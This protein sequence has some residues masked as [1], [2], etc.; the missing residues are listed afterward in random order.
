MSIGLAD[1]LPGL[2]NSFH[3][4]KFF[5]DCSSVQNVAPVAKRLYRR[6]A[7]FVANNAAGVPGTLLQEDGLHPISEEGVVKDRGVETCCASSGTTADKS[8]NH[9]RVQVITVWLAV[10]CISW[11]WRQACP[12]SG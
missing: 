5:R 3:I 7:M 9:I 4:S 6:T 11:H 12:G 2:T 8:R 10:E 1:G